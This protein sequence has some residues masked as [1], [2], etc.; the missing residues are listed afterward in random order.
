MRGC[1]GR[2]RGPYCAEGI[3][4]PQLNPCAVARAKMELE[5]RRINKVGTEVR[6]RD[7]MRAARRWGKEQ[8]QRKRRRKGRKK[9]NNTKYKA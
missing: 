2:I 6:K 1:Q 7:A 3:V 5:L 4:V 8:G 9:R